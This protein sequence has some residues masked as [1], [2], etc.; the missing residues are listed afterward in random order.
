MLHAQAWRPTVSRTPLSRTQPRHPDAFE[1]LFLEEYSKVVSIAYRVLADRGAAEDVAQE[2]FLQFH[3]S[4]SPT[5]EHA[6]GW[7]HAA[8]AHAALNVIRGERRRIKRDTAHALEESRTRMENPEHLVLEAEQRR[9]LQQAL[10]RLPV[11]AAA[12]LV[13]R[14]SGLSYA[15]VAVAL[16]MKV[17]NVGTVLRRA[18]ESLKKEVKRA[19]FE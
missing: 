16:R 5:S 7:L 19:S 15:E 8:A 18:E 12:I 11:K 6:S 4:Q 1:R 17:G 2:V 9:E 14:Y 10:S 13:L 3:R